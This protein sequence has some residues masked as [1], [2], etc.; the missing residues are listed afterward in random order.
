MRKIV[1]GVYIESKYA[2]GN[3]GIILT[4]AGVVCIDVP[5]MPD[6][7]HHWLSQIQRVTDEPILFVVQTDYDQERVLSTGLI[8]APIVAHDAASERMRIYRNEKRVQQI[9]ELL[10]RTSLGKNWQARMPDITFSE[11]LILNKGTREIHV[12]YGGGHSP[13][14]CMVYLPEDRLLFSGDVVY[15]DMHPTMTQAQTKKWLVALNQVRK[16]AVDMI[17]PGH[18]V[19]CGKEATYPLSDYIRNMRATVRRNF[20]AGR[21]KSDTSSTVIS[22]FL[23]AFPYREDERERVRRDIKGSSDRIYDEYR[24]AAR[25]SA[26]RTKGAA[27]KTRNKK[28]R[29]RVR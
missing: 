25:A 6:D 3:V 1:P 21:S 7:V 22:E 13:A 12:M 19:P 27:K 14:T 15:H 4:G 24:A 29:K 5:M 11:R 16:M 20:Q 26:E 23:D 8:D 9:R 28:R 10:G 2:S 18:G 17:V